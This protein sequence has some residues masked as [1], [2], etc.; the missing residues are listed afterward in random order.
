[1]N[2]VGYSLLS[3]AV[4]T[5]EEALRFSGGILVRMSSFPAANTRIVFFLAAILQTRAHKKA[6]F[7]NC[8]L[9]I[10]ACCS[11]GSTFKPLKEGPMDM[12]TTSAS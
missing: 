5:I 10:S 4:T 1:M 7:W 12:F 8:V 9:A 11:T 3:T 6:T 2:T